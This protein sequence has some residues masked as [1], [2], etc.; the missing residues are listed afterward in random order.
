MVDDF[1]KTVFSRH[2]RAGAHT[3][4][5]QLWQ[6]ACHKA[7]ISQARR[8]P[9]LEK[10]KYAGIPSPAESLKVFDCFWEREGQVSSINW[11]LIVNHSTEKS[12]YPGAVNQHKL[13]SIGLGCVWQKEH[14]VGYIRSWGC[15]WK[16]THR[17][18]NIFRICSVKHSKNYENKNILF[19]KQH[20]HSQIRFIES[21]CC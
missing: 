13:A 11:Q 2:N 10:E 12:S 4:L 15:S 1:K 20:V 5:M 19:W 14:E 3:N 6:T 18:M 16:S 8:D 17:R 21:Y 9:S 7:C